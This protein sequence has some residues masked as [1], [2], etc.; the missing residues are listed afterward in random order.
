MSVSAKVFHDT[1]LGGRSA[2]LSLTGSQ[3]YDLKRLVDLS[4]SGLV[5]AIRSAELGHGFLH[6]SGSAESSLYLFSGLSPV[7]SS[8][9]R[10]SIPYAML[11]T[12]ATVPFMQDFHGE[13]LRLTIPASGGPGKAGHFATS[14]VV[15]DLQTHLFAGRATSVMLANRWIDGKTEKTVSATNT[16]SA[17]WDV[18][19]SLAILVI[20]VLLGGGVAIAKIGD[21]VFTWT[22]FPTNSPNLPDNYSYLAISQQLVFNASGFGVNVWLIFYCRLSVN[23]TGQ[24]VLD[25]VDMD[26]YVWPGT[27]QGEV[28]QAIDGAKGGI[29]SALQT[30]STLVLGL[31]DTFCDDV[32][33]LP[34]TQP[35]TPAITNAS[36]LGD[37]LNDVTIVLENPR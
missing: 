6:S 12:R 30:V 9:Y 27:G 23:G 11:N 36:A 14:L 13:F 26:R 33:L 20:Q 34:G 4:P 32:Y 29:M 31:T 15:N 8:D 28:Y 7:A 16:F 1:S 17:G 35:D 10:R 37:A 3:R 21:P 2:S 19:L 25:F 22:A 24:V 18:G 5:H